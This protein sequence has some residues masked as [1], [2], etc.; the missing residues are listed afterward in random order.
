MTFNRPHLNAVNSNC[1][2]AG[3]QPAVQD[4]GAHLRAPPRHQEAVPGSQQAARLLQQD[5]GG[6]RAPPLRHLLPRRL[7]RPAVRAPPRRPRVRVQGKGQYCFYL[8][9]FYFIYLFILLFNF[10]HSILP[11]SSS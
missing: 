4:P 3:G 8:F 2:M 9:Y 1:A 5:P 11:H 7:L 6:G 10:V